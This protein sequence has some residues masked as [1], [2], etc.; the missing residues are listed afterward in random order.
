MLCLAAC[1][2]D[3]RVANEPCQNAIRMFLAESPN[4]FIDG[5]TGAAL[6]DCAA[7]AIESNVTDLRFARFRTMINLP[8]SHQ[9]P[10]DSTA[11]RHIKDRVMIGSSAAHRFSQRGNVRIIIDCNR[12]SEELCRPGG[13]RE[14][15]PALNL[16]RAAGHAS[17]PIERPTKPN[18]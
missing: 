5:P 17:S 6:L 14:I 7:R 15:G 11:E 3:V 9:S 16:M 10:A 13:Q 2:P 4:S 18:R 12:H 8:I 1:G